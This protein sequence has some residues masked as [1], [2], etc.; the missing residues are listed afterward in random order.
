VKRKFWRVEEAVVEVALKY[1]AP[2][3]VP[4]S[5]PPEY[6]VVPV[7]VNLFRPVKVLESARRVDEA[8]VP[9]ESKVQVVPLQVKSPKSVA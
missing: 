3:L 5:M 6:V 1:G 4:L 2:I 8:A 9:A 7:L